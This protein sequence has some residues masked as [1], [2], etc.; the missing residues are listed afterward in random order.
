MNSIGKI[1][2][3]KKIRGKKNATIEILKQM[4][5]N[6]NNGLMYNDKCYICNSNCLTD[7]LYL[8]EEIE[9]KFPNLIGKIQINTIGTTIGSQCGPGTVAVFFYGIIRNKL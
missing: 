5:E 4:E 1:V 7:A 8:K 2:P 9:K 3:R 6:A